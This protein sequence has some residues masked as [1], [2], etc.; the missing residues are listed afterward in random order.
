MEEIDVPTK[1][2]RIRGKKGL[3][4]LVGISLCSFFF[5]MCFLLTL[6]HFDVAPN[7]LKGQRGLREAER[8]DRSG[9]PINTRG[10]FHFLCSGSRLLRKLCGFDF[11]HFLLWHR[12]WL[13]CRNAA[14]EVLQQC[15]VNISWLPKIRHQHS[16]PQ[17]P[18]LGGT[19]QSADTITSL[20][21]FKNLEIEVNLAPNAA[22][23]PS[24]LT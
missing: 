10:P 17:L 21:Y 14:R 3:E 20:R 15:P 23:R 2:R 8:S 12:S 11:S 22:S 5:I 13:G 6:W 7:A 16:R 4:K 18:L 19:Y 24:K 9:L 1:S